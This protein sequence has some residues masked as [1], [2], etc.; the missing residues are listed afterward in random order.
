KV[1][2]AEAIG[3]AAQAQV[4]LSLLLVNLNYFRDIND[5]LGHHNGDLL[6]QRVAERLRDSVGNRGRVASLGGDEFAI[7]LPKIDQKAEVEK[8]LFDIHQCLSK[9]V[10]LADIPIKTDAT[11]GVALFP[12]HGE[13]VDQ[14]WQHADVA[15]RTAKER[16]EPHVFYSAAIDHY[17]PARL[18]LLGELSSAI[19][20]D[21]L[22]LHYQ[23][24]IDLQ[25]GK[26]V[27]VEALVRW[28]H[29]G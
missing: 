17:D 14:L 7:L 12:I 4:G 24:K 1:E 29:P 9:P 20:T 22:V 8:L 16:F 25:T 3:A 15:L 18:I 26:T 2:L 28:Q 23:P 6:L 11:L 27:G 21:Q 13:S 19:E 5:S 10:L